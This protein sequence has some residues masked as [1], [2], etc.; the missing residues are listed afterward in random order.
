M[1]KRKYLIGATL[2][3]LGALVVSGT[4]FA[5][6]PTGQTL[7][8]TVAPAKQDKK[9][10]GAASLHNIIATT[11]DNFSG[12][13]AA[14]ET[15][16]H[17]D[18]NVRFTSGN[19]PACP[20]ASL[21]ASTTTAAVQAACGAS[22]VGTGT[23]TVNNGTD[24]LFP[25]T[26]P[27][28]LVTGGNVPGGSILYVWTRIAGLTTLVLNGQ[29]NTSAG[30]LDVT[31]LPNTPGIDLTNFDTTMPKKKTGKKTY[32]VMARCKSKKWISSETTTYWNGQTTTATAPAEKCK[33]KP[34]KKKK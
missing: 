3:V 26:N 23:N 16:F 13:P 7:Q 19:L 30:T 4:A 33:Q 12:S 18:R 2:G 29:Y 31:G 28:L 1:R 20:K 9:A 8:A 21:D 10:F 25:G 11:Y 17:I 22:I 15:L 5:G 14:K 34:S 24:P 6:A 27:V 32:Y